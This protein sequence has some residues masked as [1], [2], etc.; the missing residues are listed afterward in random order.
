MDNEHHKTRFEESTPSG[1]NLACFSILTSMYEN[2]KARKHET[3]KERE[4]ER[5]R[6]RARRETVRKE[7]RIYVMCTK[8]K[9]KCIQYD[10][11]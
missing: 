7:F 11:L 1:A 9:R 6:E 3:K 8:E 4:R 10:L 2:C 5:E